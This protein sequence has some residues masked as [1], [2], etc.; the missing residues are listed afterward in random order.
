[1]CIKYKLVTHLPQ[2][3]M[4]FHRVQLCGPCCFHCSGCPSSESMEFPW[5]IKWI[6][7]TSMSREAKKKKKSAFSFRLLVLLPCLGLINVWM[8][9][10]FVNFNK[11]NTLWW[12]L[13]PV[14]LVSLTMLTWPPL[15]SYL[16]PA[17]WNLGF[18]LDIDLK[19][20]WQIVL[21]CFHLRKLAKVKSL[22]SKTTFRKSNACL[23]NILVG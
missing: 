20:D 10:N 2:C 18:K 7:V 19:L 21:F 1:M 14:G 23:W 15:A 17:V 12:C 5:I 8:A 13:V 11:K 4:G 3:H 9:Q 22:L 6:T 16:K